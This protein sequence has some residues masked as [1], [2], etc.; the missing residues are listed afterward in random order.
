MLLKEQNIDI[1]LAEKA[2][3]FYTD[4]AQELNGLIKN[5][6]YKLVEVEFIKLID[7]YPDVKRYFN[8]LSN[9]EQKSLIKAP[10]VLS[11]LFVSDETLSNININYFLLRLIEAE[12]AKKTGAFD[13]EKFGESLW[14]ADGSFMISYDSD[15]GSFSTFEHP[16][17]SNTAIPQD[18]FSHFNLINSKDKDHYSSEGL[19]PIL[20]SFEEADLVADKMN[21]VFDK[22]D[23][24]FKNFIYTYTNVLMLKKTRNE[25]LFTSGTDS[26]HI[27]RVIITNAHTVED[28]V[29]ADAMVHEAI[30]GTLTIIDIFNEWQPSR[31]VSKAFGRKIYSPW[32]NNLLTIR[33]L[34]Q[35]IYV[36]YGLYNFWKTKPINLS[37][38]YAEDRLVFIENGF[39]KLDINPY[40][41]IINSLTF[42]ELTLIKNKFI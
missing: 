20:Y 11:M 4:E 38:K 12:S 10:E 19:E 13:V 26:R 41:D 31:K 7:R 29:I 15:T 32:T 14:S 2:L 5:N 21:R 35:A 16:T 40:E 8:N 25:K 37:K 27:N 30:H 39:K 18:F 42:R 22:L 24:C 34:V 36:W 33:N 3:M 9:L 6:F 23:E 1:R 17:L 28:E